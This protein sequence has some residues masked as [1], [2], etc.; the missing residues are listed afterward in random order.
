MHKAMHKKVLLIATLALGPAPLASAQSVSVSTN[1]NLSF[2][3]VQPSAQLAVGLIAAGSAVALLNAGGVVVATVAPSGYVVPV[4]NH[5]AS[6]AVNV[7]VVTSETSGIVVREVYPVAVK[8]PKHGKVRAE[9][10]YVV[11][12]PQRV[13]LVSVMQGQHNKIKVKKGK[14]HAKGP[15]KNH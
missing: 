14:G 10:I 3:A 9:A 12:G 6:T 8:L 13:S 7:R 11:G 2:P 1:V 5:D 15:R 4:G